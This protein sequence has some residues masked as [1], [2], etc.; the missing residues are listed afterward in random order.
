MQRKAILLTVTVTLA[1]APE[2]DDSD[3]LDDGINLGETDGS[4]GAAPDDD[5]EG[6][7]DDAGDPEDEEDEGG[8]GDGDPDAQEE[9]DT[10]VSVS[11]AADVLQ[12]PAD[13]VFI[14]DNSGSMDEEAVFVQTQMNGFSA[15]IQ[16]SGVDHHVV[17]IS[18]YPGED[19]GICIEPPL[20]SGG[21]PDADDNLPVYRHVDEKVGSH[22]PLAKLIAT[23]SQWKDS[24]RPDAKKHIVVVSDDESELPLQLFADQFEAL[25]PSYEAFVFHAIVCL[26]E[27]PASA[28][29]GQTYIDLVNQTGGVLGDL[30][31]QDFQTVFDEVANAVIQGVP[32][33]CQFDIPPPPMGMTL[34][35]DLVNVELDDGKGTL[36]VIPRVVDLDDCMNHPEGWYYDDPLDPTQ[37]LL[38]PQSCTKAQGY[39]M[40]SINVQFG[41]DTYVPIG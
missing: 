35:P 1:C 12:V 18:S 5:D 4:D 15:Q 32:L 14:V 37:I 40:G 2:L 24:I 16:M 21:C 23:Q 6:D 26:S 34:E 7:S 25:D 3:L 31:Q 36:E 9:D 39:D 27:C 11:E 29:V 28:N 33:S 20:G 41:C 8:D 17:L 38:C 22:N 13:I 30:C 19:N 10:C